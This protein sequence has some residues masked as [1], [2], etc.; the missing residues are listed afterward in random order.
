MNWNPARLLNAM[1]VAIWGCPADPVP[2]W[3][4]H[5]ESLV[6]TGGEPRLSNRMRERLALGIMGMIGA[7]Y[8]SGR[9]AWTLRQLCQAL[10][11]PSHSVAAILDALQ[12]GGLL[13]QSRDNPRGYLPARDL[14]AVSVKQLLDIVRSAGE[15]GFLNPAALPVS[16]T[17]EHVLQ[18]I[19][20]SL[21]RPF[22]TMSIMELAGQAAGHDHITIPNGNLLKSVQQAAGGAGEGNRTLGSSLGS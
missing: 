4:Q 6:A 15:D 5:P 19:E 20:R 16:A 13:V 14:G 7:H 22:Q 9:P 12:D 18:S 8:L 17:V 2:A 10:Q 1:N 21:D 11:V 3:Q